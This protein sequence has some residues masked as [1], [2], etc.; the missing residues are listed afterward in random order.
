[1]PRA[2]QTMK[3][4]AIALL[5]CA[6]LLRPALAAPAETLEQRA[7]AL[8][9]SAIVLDTHLDTPMLFARP[10]WR[11]GDRHSFDADFSQVDYPRMVEGGLDGG[12][13]VIYTPQG[14]RTAAG[15]R[16]ARDFGLKRL[17]EIREMVAANA[18]RFEIALSADDAARIKKAG[19]RIVY[20]SMENASPLAS[21]PSL[22]GAYYDLGLRMLGL[23]HSSNDDFAD[24]STNPGGPE[25]NGLSDKGRA[26]VAE[27]NRLG[28]II[29]LSHASNA[30]FDQ[31]VELSKTPVVLSHTASAALNAHPR[32]IDDARLRKLAATGGV[33][34]VNSVN[35]FLIK[36]PDNA[37]RDAEVDRFFA[38]IEDGA[39][40]SAERRKQ[41]M[42]LYRE[43]EAKYPT[44]KATFEDYMKH[45][46][47]IL[48]VAGPEHVG[49]GADWDGGGGVSGMIDVTSLPKITE[50]LLR[51]GYSE[52]QVR[53]VLGGNLLR[54]MRAVE[55]ARQP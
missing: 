1:M 30:V 32:N 55:A 27:A 18:D 36:V 29:D 11:I 42:Q 4:T 12:F 10:D 15:N 13:W 5:L 9:N 16:A 23:V 54:V 17:V 48:E 6:F 19:K 22:L 26:L 50:R 44:P 51:E 33:I 47:H 21:D 7:T 31:V 14:E 8:H 37:E 28:L 34:Q 39:A 25:F 40:L 43:I 20:I 3:S 49:L 52:D 45:M 41:A 38:M 46:L 53:G 24:S 35:Q 2:I